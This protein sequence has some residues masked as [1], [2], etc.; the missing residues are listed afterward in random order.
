LFNLVMGGA[1]P[2]RHAWGVL[3]ERPP[4]PV[5]AADLT[6]VKVNGGHTFAH[7]S[8]W[9]EGTPPQVGQQVIAADGGS[10]RLPATITALRADGTIE[11]STIRAGLPAG[12]SQAPDSAREMDLPRHPHEPSTGTGPITR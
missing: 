11:L 7:I 8:N 6:F 3:D 12:L 2:M 1:F 9:D 4:F 5:L 10:R